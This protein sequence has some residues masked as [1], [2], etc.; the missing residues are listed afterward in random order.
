M[1][2]AVV[3]L[4][5]IGKV[6]ARIL[7]ERGLLSAV[8][9]TDADRL[10]AYGGAE[11][12]TDFYRLLEYGRPE[13]VH[14]CTPH[15]L[16]AEMIVAALD[17][18][19]NVLCEKPL[20][21]R[22]EEIAL[23]LR[24]AERSKAILGVCLQNRFTPA[25]RFV[26][27]YLAGKRILGASAT[28]AW[29]RDAAYYRSGDWRGTR[30]GEGG[31]VLINQAIHTLDL[32]EWFVGV[33]Q[34]LTASVSNLTLRND[35]EV[36][37][38]ATVL[39]SGGAE[40]GL[41]ASNGAPCDMPVSICVRTETET[42][43]AFPDAVLVNGTP[44]DLEKAVSGYGKECYG[45]GHGALIDCFYDCLSKGERFPIDAEEGAKS[46]RLVL[47]AYESKGNWVEL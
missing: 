40:F 27:S 39:C 24:A 17:A 36:E 25:A 41:F 4:G 16:H 22:R 18:G 15:G 1:R 21:I 31:G 30:S 44:V 26:K 38:T 2:A 23:V 12:F 32:L 6:H 14:I 20:C 7:G 35:I 33:P 8:C 47:A 42:V 37:D 10:A 43:Q 29:H 46:V 28:V 34:R 5:N 9:D 45:G 3:G 13:T 11:H 19:I